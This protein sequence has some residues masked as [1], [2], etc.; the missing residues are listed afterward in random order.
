MRSI[1]RSFLGGPLSHVTFWEEVVL[2]LSCH[3]IAYGFLAS[4]DVTNEHLTPRTLLAALL[5]FASATLP[6]TALR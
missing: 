2:E 1:P 5:R 6:V 4:A 3:L